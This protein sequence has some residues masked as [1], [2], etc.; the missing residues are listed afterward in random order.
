ML[1]KNSIS[2]FAW[3]LSNKGE[4][5]SLLKAGTSKTS[6]WS[7]S[8]LSP[9]G[10]W[11][12]TQYNNRSGK[13]S[14]KPGK[15]SKLTLKNVKGKKIKVTFKKVSKATGYQ[16]TYSTSKKF[17]KAKSVTTA[18]TTHT[19]KKLKKK[20]TYYVKVRAYQIVDGKTYYGSYSSVKKIKI[21]K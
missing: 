21:K 1:D 12:L 16:I 6:G 15:V 2:Y 14:Y 11:I 19:I 20:K 17:K 4:T 10:K 7:K 8:D 18:K 5:A 9:A 13:I 3:S